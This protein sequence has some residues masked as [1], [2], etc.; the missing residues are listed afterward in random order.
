MEDRAVVGADATVR[1]R[2][3][4]GEDAEVAGDVIVGQSAV[5]GAH[6]TVGEFVTLR[7]RA[8]VQDNTCVDSFTTLLPGETR[9]Q[10]C[11]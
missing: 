9:G 6:T 11:P 10:P 3:R 4:I 5:I 7:T 1:K 2:G 8:A